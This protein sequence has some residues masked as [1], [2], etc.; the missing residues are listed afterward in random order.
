MNSISIC[1]ST[2]SA[3]TFTARPL[4]AS[5]LLKRVRAP[6]SA[7][8]QTTTTASTSECFSLDA[9][10]L[11]VAKRQF[12]SSPRTDSGAGDSS[13][14][15]ILTSCQRPSLSPLTFAATAKTQGQQLQQQRQVPVAALK[16]KHSS[17]KLPSWP[18]VTSCDNVRSAITFLQTSRQ[19]AMALMLQNHW[20][21]AVGVLEKIEKATESVCKQRRKVVI[22][23]ANAQLGL[24]AQIDD[25]GL[26]DD[27]LAAVETLAEPLPP[28]R[29]RRCV[30]FSEHV[31]VAIADDMD[32]ASPLV[33]V[34]A[35]EEV[36]VL[37]ASRAIPQANL[38]EFW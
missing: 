1:A 5:M 32:R 31:S 35:R 21:R 23:Q 33:P 25:L 38:S 10:T 4:A 30:R 15:S 19:H 37:R 24:A 36:F 13:A 8:V 22:Q 2:S 9:S 20:E 16:Q 3:T 7:F 26:S 28:P 6:P 18:V 17:R 27:E 29:G 11:K 14:V 12:G 34:P